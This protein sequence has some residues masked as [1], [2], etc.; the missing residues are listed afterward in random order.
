MP[1]AFLK[2]NVCGIYLGEEIKTPSTAHGRWGLDNVGG[3]IVFSLAKVLAFGASFLYT[4]SPF[5][6]QILFQLH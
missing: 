1:S 6:S 5:G 3:G 2:T 4:I